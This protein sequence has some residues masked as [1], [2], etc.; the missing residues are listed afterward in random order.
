MTL[1]ERITGPASNVAIAPTERFLH[2]AVGLL[3]GLDVVLEQKR[4]R[5]Y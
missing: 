4:G 3:V 1:L 2:H 5:R